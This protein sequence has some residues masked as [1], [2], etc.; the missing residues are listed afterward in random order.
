MS[1]M[2]R[3]AADFDAFYSARYGGLVHTLYL[4]CGDWVRAEDAAQEAFLRAWQRWGQLDEDPIGWVRTAA[5]RICVDDWRSQRR[6]RR[7]LDRVRADVPRQPPPDASEAL[8]RIALLSPNL[9]SVLVLHYAEDLSVESI[10]AL[11]DRPVGTV[12]SRLSRARDA[13][14]AHQTLTEGSQLSDEL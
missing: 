10:A 9:R 1:S 2:D 11:L 5:W 14:R 4:A 3:D 8:E 7:A 6:F 12:K 13:L